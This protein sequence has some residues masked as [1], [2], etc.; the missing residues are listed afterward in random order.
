[1]NSFTVKGCGERTLLLRLRL[2]ERHA[3]PECGAGGGHGK[4]R[5]T[6]AR[7]RPHR[8]RPA[9]CVR[10]K[11]HH[12]TRPDGREPCHPADAQSEQ[13]HGTALAQ[14]ELH[15][16][17]EHA[18]RPARERMQEPTGG[19]HARNEEHLVH[20]HRP[21]RQHQAGNLRRRAERTDGR[22]LRPGRTAHERNPASHLADA[23][24]ALPRQ[25]ADE[26]TD[27]GGNG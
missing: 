3:P 16:D 25:T 23:G 19:V 18:E 17:A 6:D 22:D 12:G 4:R 26:R 20:R 21:E 1:M 11:P 15:A 14:P 7:H 2:H 5:A 10:R 8:E 27:A 24:T 13:L 9:V